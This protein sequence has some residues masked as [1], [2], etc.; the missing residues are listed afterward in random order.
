[1]GD[2][3]QRS[4]LGHTECRAPRAEYCSAHPDGDAGGVRISL[5]SSGIELGTGKKGNNAGNY[6]LSTPITQ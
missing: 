1:M 2:L 3:C 4:L 5:T 6:F